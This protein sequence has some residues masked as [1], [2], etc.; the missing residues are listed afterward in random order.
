M[1]DFPK[2]RR[3]AFF[4]SVLRPIEEAHE[5]KGCVWQPY[6]RPSIGRQKIH[7]AK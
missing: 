3:K 2:H 5:K 7:N 4:F 6:G 1:L